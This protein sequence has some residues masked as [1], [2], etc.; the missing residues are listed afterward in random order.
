MLGDPQVLVLDEPANGLDP[1]GIAWLRTTLR[2]LAGEGR[3]SSAI[4]RRPSPRR[5][6]GSR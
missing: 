2:D 6:P 5:W 1:G 4:P 3:T